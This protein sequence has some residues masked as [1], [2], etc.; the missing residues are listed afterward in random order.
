MPLSKRLNLSLDDLLSLT[1]SPMAVVFVCSIGFL[2][3]Q[4][5]QRFFVSDRLRPVGDWPCAASAAWFPPDGTV[6]SISYLMECKCKYLCSCFC[7]SW[8]H[9]HMLSWPGRPTV[10]WP[11][12]V[13]RLD[14]AG[15]R[16]VQGL[17]FAM[18][19][20]Q[21]KSADFQAA[22]AVC[23][24]YYAALIAATGGDSVFLY[25]CRLP[26][27]QVGPNRAV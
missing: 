12:G 16:A 14:V 24:T 19:I 10:C 15:D 2:L 8:L 1:P 18:R 20:P 4:R 27:S 7:C 5:L 6:S 21:D 22:G 13:L 23:C 9:N 17:C 3:V 11:S 26:Q 25:L